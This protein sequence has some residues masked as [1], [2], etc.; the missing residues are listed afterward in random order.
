[1]VIRDLTVDTLW[2]WTTPVYPLLNNEQ[3]KFLVKGIISDIEEYYYTKENKETDEIN[4]GK[5]IGAFDTA[6]FAWQQK[7]K[8]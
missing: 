4:E 8:K 7:K 2:V 1:M 5:V 3:P 6:R